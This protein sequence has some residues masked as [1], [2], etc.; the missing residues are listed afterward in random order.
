MEST[1]TTKVILDINGNDARKELE[2]QQKIIESIKDTMAQVAASKGVMSDEFKQLENKLRQAQKALTKYQAT[3]VELTEVLKKLDVANIKDLERVNSAL[4]AQLKSGAIE[5]G[6]EKWNELLKQLGPVRQE[7]TNVKAETDAVM[8]TVQN[9]GDM[10]VNELNKA[11]RALQTLLATQ[12]RNTERWKQTGEKI[13]EIQRELD[14]ATAAQKRLIAA[15]DTEPYGKSITE[16]T[17][18]KSALE[19]TLSVQRRGTSEWT[20]TSQQLDKVN[21]ELRDAEL[22]TKQIQSGS[23]GSVDGKSREEL[24][25]MKQVL[26]ETLNTQTQGTAEWKNTFA[27]IERVSAAIDKVD[28]ETK[29]ASKHAIIDPKGL[30]LADL[31]KMETTLSAIIK[32]EKQ[33]T[34]EWNRANAKLKEVKDEMYRLDVESKRA[35]VDVDRVLRNLSTSNA[36]ELR[37][38]LEV[39][40]KELN[41]PNIKR[42]SEEWKRYNEQLKQVA[43]ELKL[44]ESE[45]KETKSW[46]DRF[47]DG[48]N[49]WQTTIAAAA[50]AI[51]G[52]YN[53]L[54]EMR[55]FSF[56]KEDATSKLKAITGLDDKSIFWLRDQARRLSTEMDETGMRVRQSTADI[57]DAFRLVGSNKP[58]LLKDREG[59]YEVTKEVIRLAQAANMEL[60]PTVISLTT[61]LNQ[62]GQGADAAR[63]YVNALA[64]GSKYGAADVENQA[65]V[66]VRSGV[67]ANLA[68]VSFED[69][70]AATETLAETGLK[71]ER[72]G[73]SMKTVFTRMELGAKDCRP[74]IVG[75]DQALENMA[76]KAD[77]VQ[78]LKKTFGLWSYSAAKTLIDHR[79]SLKKYRKAVT[80]TNVAEEQAA[81]MGKNS[82]AIHTQLVNKFKELS[83]DLYEIVGPSI[84]HVTS[85][86]VN[87]TRTVK[88]VIKWILEHK[89]AI[90]LLIIQYTSLIAIMKAE[91]IAAAAVNL[92][93]TKIVAGINLVIKG[94][95]GL[96]AAGG[97]WVVIANLILSAAIA[98]RQYQKKADDAARA[99]A[100]REKEIN[101]RLKEQDHQ[102]GLLLQQY[103]LMEQRLHDE[104][105][106]MKD[107][108][109]ILNE[110]NKAVPEYKG[111]ID[112]LTGAVKGNAS[113]LDEWVKK[114]RMISLQQIYN[115]EAV[116]AM[117]EVFEAEEEYRKASVKERDSN[118][119]LQ[120]AFG[121]NEKDKPWETQNSNYGM[122]KKQHDDALEEFIKAR[123]RLDKA[124]KDLEQLEDKIGKISKEAE[125]MN[126]L[127]TFDASHDTDISNLQNQ[128][129]ELK[130]SQI[131]EA[132]RKEKEDARNEA[133][134]AKLEL[135]EQLQ[136]G[137]IEPETY[138]E[139]IY[140]VEAYMLQKYIDICK[141]WYKEDSSNYKDA[142]N[143][144]LKFEREHIE[145]SMKIDDKSRKQEEKE[146][147]NDLKEKLRY[148]DAETKAKKAAALESKNDAIAS[149]EYSKEAI[150]LKYNQVVFEIEQEA[151]DK[152][153]KLY[154]K[155]SDRY[156]ELAAEKMLAEEEYLRTIQEK[157]VDIQNRLLARRSSQYEAELEIMREALRKQLIT[158]EQY[159]KAVILLR[160]K[161]SDSV[162]R[163]T[164]DHNR[165]MNLSNKESIQNIWKTYSEQIE[166]IRLLY[167]EGTISAEQASKDLK[168]LD[169]QR[170]SEIFKVYQEDLKEWLS[171]YKSI[172]SGFQN[173]LSSYSAMVDANYER[174]IASIEARY[175]IEIAA[176][177]KAG[178]NTK[179]LEKEKAIA[180]AEIQLRQANAKKNADVA[181]ALINVAMSITEGYAQYGPII[182]SV[183]AALS[184][185]MGTMQ[186]ATINSQYEA[187]KSALNAT[188]TINGFYEGGYTRGKRYHQE[189]GVVHEG[190]FV[191]NH[192]AVNN[193]AIRPMLDLIDV[194]QRNNRV[195][196]LTPEDLA[197]ANAYRYKG[198]EKGGYT[199][200]ENNPIVVT[201]TKPYVDH[202]LNSLLR[203]LNNQLEAGIYSYTT[204][205]GPN[206]INRKQKRFNQLK[207]NKS[208]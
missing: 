66:I 50:A 31:K 123:N 107:K 52:L 47:N 135:A 9:V 205:D 95:K 197:L 75:L 73:T 161:E 90:T 125:K 102:N 187:Q 178:R 84:L 151:F 115:D 177:E 124:K 70:V 2:R 5:R 140:K 105:L 127:Y 43:A 53:Q 11:N 56:A 138:A 173:A 128:A 60:Q 34:D 22:Y 58:E 6:S 99:E 117:Q 175:D 93:N 59:L 91:A 37:K 130:K 132:V 30:P 153:M 148:I 147:K 156:K 46:I 109:K 165:Q 92:W 77:D 169:K 35:A 113:A 8:A 13:Q 202:E 106:A 112:K 14:N 193:P 3:C 63:K 21:K 150:N 122:W 146:E 184:T 19:Q 204:I 89:E 189:A 179:K 157:A 144:K 154:D 62:F 80:D 136:S 194:A 18:M 149:G 29:K 126:A 159:S 142:V 65:K 155:E 36:S 15:A 16:L 44:V 119:R 108:I 174:Q 129:D 32:Q 158:Q 160:R 152:K 201:E 87:W 48:M 196:N 23:F 141:K 133:E 54:I 111:E 134:K 38:T 1:E 100:L 94:F 26:Q 81:I 33:G 17:R 164:A 207:A 76:S 25:R 163:E 185:A 49:N 103:K 39:L 20:N 64:A 143:D 28:L 86:M 41:S 182:G 10:S 190:E 74:S 180:V 68:K 110:L 181:Q 45:G 199:S 69:L 85:K 78:W 97:V 188:K 195:A 114:Q 61:A 168:D 167:K 172:I 208:R 79:E 7:L 96:K 176:A 121:A 4:T 118:A 12:E 88:M 101:E 206:G 42:G 83:D 131:A 40:N 98:L 192:D 120:G 200:K 137:L 116:K 82:V 186:I 139:E 55:N 203:E 72:A 67:A 191:A 183:I 145:K 57:M 162:F 198:Y 170:L 171:Q 24:L 71:G 27:Q 51:F 104:N 166:K